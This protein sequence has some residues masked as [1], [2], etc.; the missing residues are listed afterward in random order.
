[1]FLVAPVHVLVHSSLPSVFETDGKLLI[2]TPALL[3]NTPWPTNGTMALVL[4]VSTEPSRS[5]FMAW[6]AV[7]LNQLIV[8]IVIRIW[9]RP[10]SA[11]KTP[12]PE[13]RLAVPMPSMRQAACGA[14]LPTDTHTCRKGLEV[15]APECRRECH[16]LCPSGCIC[17]QHWASDTVSHQ[18]DLKHEPAPSTRGGPPANAHCI[19]HRAPWIA[20]CCG[21]H[22]CVAIGGCSR[23]S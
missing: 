12:R 9:P 3:V 11:L 15:G 14:E 17:I 22:A 21:G 10:C 2:D 20:A 6:C 23:A 1:M 13:W 7:P 19:T 8:I 4:E 5:A 18:S 16:C